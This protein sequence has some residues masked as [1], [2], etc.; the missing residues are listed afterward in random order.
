MPQ[1]PVPS[2]LFV[3]K[4]EVGDGL[5]VTPSSGTGIVTIELAGAAQEIV[6]TAITTVGAGTLT[7]ASIVGQLITRSG[8]VAAFSDTTATALQIVAALASAF[9]GQSFYVTIKNTTAF[10]QTVL[11]GV[12]VSVGGNVVIPA[13]STG[14]FLLTV[15]S[16]TAV[17]LL[18]VQVSPLT[19]IAPEVTTALTTNGAG[20]ITA[21][22]IAGGVTLRSGAA[23]AATD[24]TATADL[25]I[26][27]RPNVAIGDS[28]EYTYQNN[29]AFAMTLVGGVGVTVSGTTVVSPQSSSR[30]LVTYTAASTITIVGIAN[31]QNAPLPPTKFTTAALAAG[32]IPAASIVGAKMCIWQNTGATPGAQTFPTAA[33][34]FAAIPGAYV[35]LVTMFRVVNTG[36]GTLTLTADAGPTITITGTAATITNTWRDYTLTFTSAIAATVQSVGSGVSP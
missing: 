12:G 36:A 24:T 31:G 20:V 6:N 23:A 35:G 30:F 4:I 34:L 2:T 33:T 1:K 13:H 29:V 15:T 16:L 10:P 17:S 18:G 27:A 25:I 28:W 19:T 14:T 22:G 8:S 26:A 11:P 32:T 5:A 7:A 9:A 3:S 21:A